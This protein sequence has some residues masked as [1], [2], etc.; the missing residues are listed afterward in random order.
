VSLRMNIRNRV[1]HMLSWRSRLR[2]CSQPADCLQDPHR[3]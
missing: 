3:G 1:P 2:A